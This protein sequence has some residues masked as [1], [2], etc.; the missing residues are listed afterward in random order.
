[1]VAIP[2]DCHF[3]LGMRRKSKY[4]L[5]CGNLG[6]KRILLNLNIYPLNTDHL[7]HA[8]YVTETKFKVS[9][10]YTSQGFYCGFNKQQI[11]NN[12]L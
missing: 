6:E 1:M 5:G 7:V 11:N 3:V 4:I 8:T 2:F 12:L 10:K 9:G